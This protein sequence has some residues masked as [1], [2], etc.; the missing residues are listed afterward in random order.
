M[1]TCSLKGMSDEEKASFIKKRPPGTDLVFNGH[2]MMLLGYEEDRIY[3]IS[4]VSDLRLPGDSEN[5]RVLGTVINTLDIWR[6]DN[7]TWLHHLYEAMIP[8]CSADQL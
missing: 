2:E 5:T 8:F 3:V 1:K 7:Q 4:P 6:E